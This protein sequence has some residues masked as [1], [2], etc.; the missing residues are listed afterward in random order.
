MEQP[1]VFDIS[2]GKISNL[3]STLSIKLNRLIDGFKQ[4]YGSSPEFITRVPGRYIMN[5]LLT[6]FFGHSKVHYFLW[7]ITYLFHFCR[8][9]LI[10]EHVDYCGYAVFPMAIEQEIL[11]AVQKREGEITDFR[12][13]LQTSISIVEISSHL[14]SP[15]RIV[16]Y[17]HCLSRFQLWHT[18]N[19]VICCLFIASQFLAFF[20]YTFFFW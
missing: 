17:Q 11:I 14:R 20:I 19:Q 8:V 10:G 18:T 3:D 1:P 2:N 9:N 7:G 4:K 5:Q 13:K 12:N 15:I 16:Q 6:I